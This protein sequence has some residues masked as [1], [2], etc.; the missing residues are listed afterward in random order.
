MNFSRVVRVILII[1]NKCDAADNNNNL[2]MI[3]ILFAMNFFFYYYYSFRRPPPS[4]PHSLPMYEACGH[5][6]NAREANVISL[7]DHMMLSILP[8]VVV[9][10]NAPQFGLS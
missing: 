1:M 9:E 2:R 6:W 8:L 4:S 3:I 10:T 5:W 7:N